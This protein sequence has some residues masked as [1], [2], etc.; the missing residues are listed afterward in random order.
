[1][2]RI[3]VRK[4]GKETDWIPSRDINATSRI[5]ER[6]SYICVEGEAKPSVY[7]TIPDSWESKRSHQQAWVT[8]ETPLDSSDIPRVEHQEMYNG[9]RD[10]NTYR[11]DQ[12]GREVK[13]IWEPVV[14]LD[15]KVWKFRTKEINLVRV[16]WKFPKGQDSTWES[17]E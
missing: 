13:V 5:L 16:H 8:R 6:Y 14:I 2:L 12:C 10:S 17:E 3:D 9:S 11:W 15:R 1:M 4:Q 7:G